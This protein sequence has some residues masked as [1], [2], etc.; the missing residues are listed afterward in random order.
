MPCG[1]LASSAVRPRSV[2]GPAAIR[3]RSHTATSPESVRG[4]KTWPKAV[5][6]FL[7]EEGLS[8]KKNS[9]APGADAA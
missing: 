1:Q 3:S 8:F 6:I 7:H 4:V 2:T 5:W 9:A